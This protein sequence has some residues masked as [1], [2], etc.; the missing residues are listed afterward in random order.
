MKS[1]AWR[2]AA[3]DQ[4]ADEALRALCAPL[5]ASLAR[6]DQRAR[7]AKYVEGLL[8]TEGRRSFRNMAACLGD[9]TAL[10][11]RLH[12][13]VSCSTWD[14]MPVRRALA[15]RA[16][17]AAPLD[18][19]VLR[20][21]LTPK[22]GDDIAGVHR[23]YVPDLGAV[24]NVQYAVGLWA[25]SGAQCQPVNWQLLRP[26]AADAR[27]DRP[28]GPLVPGRSRA[29]TPTEC[30]IEVHLDLLNGPG[31][32]LPSRPV[33]MAIDGIDVIDAVRRLRAARLPFL[34]K[35]GRAVPLGLLT[36]APLSGAEDLLLFGCR[37]GGESGPD[38]VWLTDLLDA[39]PAELVALAASAR[40]VEESFARVTDPV[41]ARDFTGRTFDGWHR[42]LTLVSVAHEVRA[43]AQGPSLP[44]ESVLVPG[45]VERVRLA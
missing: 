34:I 3:G 14:W 33:V 6:S 40:T 31:R 4:S 5:F 10:E 39:R 25:V 7:A 2:E 22:E 15:A 38:E 19:W 18:V 28:G 29:R 17:A 45:A 20:P 16:A 27:T 11:Q 42:H 23:R 36:P 43:T 1:A 41:G 35:V 32:R 13:F 37:A 26:G 30:A 8:V 12:H 21:M 24:R 44:R 9:G